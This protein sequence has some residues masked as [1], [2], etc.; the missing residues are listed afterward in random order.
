MARALILSWPA[1]GL[2][3]LYVNDQ[4]CGLPHFAVDVVFLLFLLRALSA[5][6]DVRGAGI[7]ACDRC[8]QAVTDSAEGGRQSPC[9]SDVFLPATACMNR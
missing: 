1:E 9:S 3:A 2:S 5:A 4:R 7:S 8:A 6:N